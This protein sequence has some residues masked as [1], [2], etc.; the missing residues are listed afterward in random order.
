MQLLSKIFSLFSCYKVKVIVI[1]RLTATRPV[2]PGVRSQLGPVTN[3]FFSLNFSWDWSGFV[4]LWRPLW[5]EDGSV[6]C[7]C[8]FASPA[9]SLSGLSPAGLNTI[10]YCLIWN[11]P[12]WK[13][14]SQYLYPPGRGWPSYTPGHWVPFSS[15][16]TTRR[17]T[18]G[19]SNPP[20]LRLLYCYSSLHILY[21]ASSNSV[22]P[23]G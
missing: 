1:L 11:S 23:S 22:N 2:W 7:C 4:I 8:C 20:P 3:L 16:L 5:R 18:V 13:A 15:P 14:R 10:F 21:Q 6:I 12:T 19:Y 9:Q 17:A